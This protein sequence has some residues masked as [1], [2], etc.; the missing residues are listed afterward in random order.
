MPSAG[1]RPTPVA[2]IR[3]SLLNALPNMFWSVL[4]LAPVYWFCSQS[5]TPVHFYAFG[6]V[7]LVPYLLP[8]SLIERLR[9][10]STPTLYRR[11]GVPFI[12]RFTQDGALVRKISGRSPTRQSLHVNPAKIAGLRRTSLQRERF[13]LTGFVFFLLLTARAIWL[14]K[15]GWTLVLLISNVVYNAYPILLQQYVR[16]RL[17]R[18]VNHQQASQT[19]QLQESPASLSSL[20]L[21]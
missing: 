17:A 11:V 13:H 2:K 7:S 4:C 12:N 8:A 19:R 20:L 6:A 9:I 18:I 16:L 10:S 5:M 21:R 3:I 14:G 1:K 15:V